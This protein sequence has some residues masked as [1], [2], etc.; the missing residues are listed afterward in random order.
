MVIGGGDCE[1]LA[2]ALL[3]KHFLGHALELSRVVKSP[4][5][6]NAALTLGKPWHRMHGSNSAGVGEG[7]GGALEVFCGQLVV[8]GSLYQALVCRNK[9]REVQRLCALDVWHQKRSG[10]I[11]L[12][13]VDCQSEVNVG[14]RNR[15]WL[16]IDFVVVDIL[17]GKL[18]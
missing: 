14:R 17:R 2:N 10:A 15:S 11:R 3:R 12:W 6:N 4:N 13:D 8:P 7:N 1:N 18:F 9:F 5:A 16:A